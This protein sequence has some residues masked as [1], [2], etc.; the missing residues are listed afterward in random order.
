MGG[1]LWVLLGVVVV[2]VVVVFGVDRL[3]QARRRRDRLVVR[4]IQRYLEGL[5]PARP[6]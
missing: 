3:G 2:A 5:P 6:W 4:R 1:V